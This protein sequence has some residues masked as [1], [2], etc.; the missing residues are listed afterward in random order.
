MPVVGVEVV[1]ANSVANESVTG[2]DVL[3]AVTNKPVAVLM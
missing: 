2:V 1:A 3:A